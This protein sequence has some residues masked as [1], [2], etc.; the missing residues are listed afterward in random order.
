MLGQHFDTLWTYTRAIGD[1]KDNDNRIDRG[2]SKD[3]VAD[4]LRSLGIKLYTSN[5]TNE[6]LFQDLLGLSPSGSATPDTG[7]Q[8]VETYVSVS[9]EANTTDT[10]NKEVYKR[11]YNTLPYL[12]KT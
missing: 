2:I 10:L 11:I 12:L 9:N 5:R 4:T 3:L 6:N 8:R 1:I 7:S